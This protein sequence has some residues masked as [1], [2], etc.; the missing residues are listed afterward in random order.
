[1]KCDD[2]DES[3]VDDSSTRPYQGR[4][5]QGIELIRALQV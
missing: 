1:L 4:V 5:L 3:T 2:A